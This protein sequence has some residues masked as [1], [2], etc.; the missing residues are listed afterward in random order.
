[1]GFNTNAASKPALIEALSLA[2]ERGDLMVLDDRVLVSELEMFELEPMAS[3]RFKF[4]APAGSHDD[5]VIALALA[6]E[7]ASHTGMVIRELDT[8]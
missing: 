6:W 8:D 5:C 1:V 7:A 3:G 4:G 2:V